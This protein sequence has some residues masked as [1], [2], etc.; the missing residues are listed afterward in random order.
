[1]IKFSDL[2]TRDVQEN[3]WTVWSSLFSAIA[4]HTSNSQR[5]FW[6]CRSTLTSGNERKGLQASAWLKCRGGKTWHKS[7]T[8]EISVISF[9]HIR[10]SGWGSLMTPVVLISTPHERTHIVHNYDQHTLLT[11]S[12]AAYGPKSLLILSHVLKIFTRWLGGTY[13]QK[14]WS[15][16]CWLLRSYMPLL[17]NISRTFQNSSAWVRTA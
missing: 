10:N 14:V 5:E 3:G 6:Q 8:V 15:E 4:V 17:R 7:Y 2:H 1:M 12:V 13:Q 16:C 9:Q 11:C